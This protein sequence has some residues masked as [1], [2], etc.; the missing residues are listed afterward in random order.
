MSAKPQP[1]QYGDRQVYSVAGFNHGVGGWLQRLPEVW[2]DGELAEMKQQSGW[3]YAYLTL[4]DPGDGA[5]LQALVARSR[6][7]AIQPPLRPGDRVHARGRAELYAKRGEL[8]LRVSSIEPFGLGLMLRQIEELKRRLGDEGLFAPERKRSLPL[9]PRVVGVICGREAAAKRDVIETAGVR[10]PPAQ[11]RVA[12]VA[13][14][15]PG[16]VPQILAALERLDRDDE[17]DVIVLARG[18]GSFED[19]LPFSDERLVRAVALCRTPV[20][21]AIGHEQDTPIVDHVADLRAGTPSLAARLVVPDYA[22]ITADLDDLAARAGRALQTRT[23]RCRESLAM[24]VSRPAFSDPRSWI[25]VRR[26]SLLR[27][28][29]GLDRWPRGRLERERVRVG[30]AFDRLRLLGPAATLDRG[31]AIVQDAAGTV[32]T[33]AD[34]VT[35]GQRIGV[36]LSQGR[37]AATVE[38]VTE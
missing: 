33:A 4:K 15:G 38:E 37:I 14:Q 21:S 25:A 36:R 11:F 16:A 20:V 35:A 34:A 28:R 1:V 23:H 5:S 7:E 30:H 3:T 22:A 12:E 2:V 19:L 9:L 31:Y 13:V 18:G 10:Y 26:E 32:V 17:V 27:V 8:R 29:D 6:L 24:L